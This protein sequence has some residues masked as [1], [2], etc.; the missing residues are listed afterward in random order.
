MYV[1]SF[2]RFWTLSIERFWF[3]FWS[4]LNGVTLKTSNSI[5]AVFKPI[6]NPFFCAWIISS[7]RAFS[8]TC[9]GSMQIYWNK[10][11]RL[12]KKRVQLPQDWFVSPTWPL[13]HCFETPIWPPWRHLET[14]HIKYGINV[15]N[16]SSTK[17]WK[18][19]TCKPIGYNYKTWWLKK[20]TPPSI[21]PSSLAPSLYRFP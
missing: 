8:L 18:N 13:F 6:L 1:L 11:K 12:Q 7:H 2:P 3:L 5:N 9:P 19:G 4:T 17:V 15:L 20:C 10:G 21:E 14:L 16:W